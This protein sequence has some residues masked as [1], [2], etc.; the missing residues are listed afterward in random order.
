M[1]NLLESW[2]A[3]VEVAEAA[4]FRNNVMITLLSWLKI[5]L[6][7]HNICG[8]LQDLAPFCFLFYQ[9]YLLRFLL[10]LVSRPAA[11]SN[12]LIIF[13]AEKL[14]VEFFY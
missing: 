4:G 11:K 14:K 3:A 9:P 7:M 2:T 13:S 5:Y 8:K 1:S 12:I 6:A 10:A